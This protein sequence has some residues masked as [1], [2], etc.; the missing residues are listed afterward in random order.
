MD[1]F[2]ISFEPFGGSLLSA[3]N[4]LVIPERITEQIIGH[5]SSGTELDNRIELFGDNNNCLKMEVK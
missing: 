4:S 2:A 1:H 5:Y 3:L